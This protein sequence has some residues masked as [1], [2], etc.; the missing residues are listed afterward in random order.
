MARSGLRR[1]A[2]P[3][4]E[5]RRPERYRAEHR[6]TLTPPPNEVVEEEVVVQVP[7]LDP[8]PVLSEG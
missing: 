2:F 3:L 8:V 7:P 6:T 1:W 5:G 4:I